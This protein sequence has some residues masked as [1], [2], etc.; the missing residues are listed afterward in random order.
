M[1]VLSRVWRKSHRIDAKPRLS[2][3]LLWDIC[4]RA[5]WH[6]GAQA[7]RKT[8]AQDATFGSSSLGC[9]ILRGVGNDQSRMQ[10]QETGKP[11]MVQGRQ[12]ADSGTEGIPARQFC[13]DRRASLEHYREI[14]DYQELESARSRSS[15]R[16]LLHSGGMTHESSGNRNGP[17][18]GGTSRRWSGHVDLELRPVNA[19]IVGPSYL[20]VEQTGR[21]RGQIRH[22]ADCLFQCCV[23]S[24][25]PC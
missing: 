7:A 16:S 4:V 5:V 12:I 6:L 18:S 21:H 22:D 3:C 24:A 1:V 19:R 20:L 14:N 17:G 15:V 2:P 10:H 11:L 23:A 9:F 25:A 8:N 13:R